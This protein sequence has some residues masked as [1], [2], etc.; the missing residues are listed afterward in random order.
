MSIPRSLRPLAYLATGLAVGGLG[1]T[2]FR[3]SLPGA[4]GSPEEQVRKLEVKL[5]DAQNQ[6]VVLQGSGRT[7]QGRTFA[8][9]A[10][11]IV[12]DIRAGRPV[13][14]EDLFRASQP[15][16]RD[17]SPIF[18]RMRIREEKRN[19]DSRMGE[20]TRKYDLTPDQEEK[21]KKWFEQKVE[22][23]AKR[24]S[25]LVANDRTTLEDL[26]RESEAKRWDD[27]LDGFMPSILGGEKLADFR[28][29]RMNEKIESVQEEADMRV[30]RVDSVVHLDHAQR[31]Q[32]FAIMA[33]GSRDYDPAMV[34][35]G[36]SGDIGDTPGGGDRNQAMLSVL[37]PDQRA[38]W[39]AERE[40]RRQETSKEMNEM[41]LSMPRNWDPLEDY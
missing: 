5:K 34:L 31:E 17:L 15:L 33:R 30:E 40:R 20:L 1:A 6:I 21:L 8:D 3:E 4:A 12:E 26:M 39:E 28:E 35:E 36:A 22:A 11:G 38:A 32:V 37:R 29:E 7:K 41:G 23:D 24:F 10:R 13:S 14:P 18:D 19:I 27:G 2:L 25:D 9:G 16:L